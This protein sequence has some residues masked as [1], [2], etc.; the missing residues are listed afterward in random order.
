VL[1]DGKVIATPRPVDGVADSLRETFRIP[2]AP[3]GKAAARTCRA[4]DA[5][6]NT[7]EAE[8]PAP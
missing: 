7:A 1:Q 5:A 4:T 2:D 8:V 6:G 3:G